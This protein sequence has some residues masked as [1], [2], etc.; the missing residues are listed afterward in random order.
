LEIG[1][2]EPN[3]EKLLTIDIWGFRFMVNQKSNASPGAGFENATGFGEIAAH[4]ALG[5]RSFEGLEFVRPERFNS[6]QPAS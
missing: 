4:E 2:P 6:P 1:L 3:P 5:K